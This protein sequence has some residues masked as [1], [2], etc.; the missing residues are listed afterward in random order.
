MFVLSTTVAHQVN[1]IFVI[2]SFVNE[3]R[4][5]RGKNRYSC[6]WW[7][8]N[9]CNWTF[10]YA[11]C[12]V[13]PKIE[14]SSCVMCGVLNMCQKAMKTHENFQ[15]MASLISV[16][17]DNFNISDS[18]RWWLNITLIKL[19]KLREQWTQ[20]T[21]RKWIYD[22]LRNAHTSWCVE[23]LSCFIEYYYLFVY[24][25]ILNLLFTCWF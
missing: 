25:L 22:H 7:K 15:L 12:L 23:L 1:K 17:F 9:P 5:K 2:I 10:F 3:K 16:Q 11:L 24:Q 13:I 20:R 8:K 21:I 19:H 14:S 4:K 18:A 6:T